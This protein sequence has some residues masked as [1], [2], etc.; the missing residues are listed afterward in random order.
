VLAW[1]GTSHTAGAWAD[2]RRRRERAYD[3]LA[4][5]LEA[6]V[7]TKVFARLLRR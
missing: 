3:R 7:G 5:A 6:A 4:D 1:A 2:H